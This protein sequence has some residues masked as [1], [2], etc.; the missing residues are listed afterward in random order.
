MSAQPILDWSGVL[1]PAEGELSEEEIERQY[2]TLMQSA[3]SAFRDDPS[4]VIDMAEAAAVV[5][6]KRT[7]SESR[8]EALRHT[9]D[10]EE[11]KQITQNIMESKGYA[12]PVR[13][14]K[15]QT[16]T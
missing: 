3:V 9:Q 14:P 12:E 11:V 16:R 7:L 2:G 10:R 1:N 5:K 4:Y 13:F 15:R 8:L 6:Y